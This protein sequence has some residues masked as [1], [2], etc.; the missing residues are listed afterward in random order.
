MVRNSENRR[1]PIIVF[2]ADST[3]TRQCPHRQFLPVDQPPPRRRTFIDSCKHVTPPY[4]LGWWIPWDKLPE[5]FPGK[6]GHISDFWQNEVCIPWSQAGYH[7]KYASKTIKKFR[8]QPE[9]TTGTQ[10]RDTYLFIYI[11]DNDTQ[12]AIDMAQNE[13]YIEDV[14]RVAQI[15]EDFVEKLQWLRLGYA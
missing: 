11:T 7:D 9:L 14:K 10:N 8:Y 1:T 15:R 5:Y 13:E 6:A 3:R 12:E 2:M 4:Q